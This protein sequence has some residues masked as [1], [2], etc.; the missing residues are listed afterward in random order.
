MKPFGQDEFRTRTLYET[1]SRLLRTTIILAA[2]VAPAEAQRGTSPLSG[3]VLFAGSGRP[4][5][6]VQIVDQTSTIIDVVFTDSS[7]RFILRAPLDN[8]GGVYL[9]IEEDGF[10]P[11]RERLNMRQVAGLHT[12]Y[13]E[14]ASDTVIEPAGGD[15][16]NLVDLQ[17]L[18]ARIPDEA[19]EEYSRAVEDVDLG[20]TDDA[21]ERLERVVKM[22][23]EFYD[24]WIKLGVQHMDRGRFESAEAAL[25]AARE[26]NPNGALAPLNLAILRYQQAE[27]LRN[28]GK[29]AE[30]LLALAEGRVFLEDAILLNPVSA[31]AVSYLGMTL[32][33]LGAYDES[34][35]ALLEALGMEGV[36]KE[37]RLMLINVYTR[38]NRFEAALEQAAAFLQENP[39]APERPAI[40]QVQQQIE[41][42]L[43]R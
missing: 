11:V 41:T 7:G 43:G 16:S 18:T 36:S 24:A 23:P 22:A 3:Q 35:R 40:E 14:P 27:G 26:T 33:R 8:P 12:I 30:A 17:Q 15:G 13:L 37:V 42:A 38:Q 28:D 5:V 25:N 20:R 6:A 32:Y 29:E 2:L 39:D 10:Q 1:V 4:N 9:T 34:E 21:L 19:R 31:P